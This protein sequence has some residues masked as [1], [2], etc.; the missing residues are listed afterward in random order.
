LT[1]RKGVLAVQPADVGGAAFV[2]IAPGDH[3]SLPE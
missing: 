1:E 3:C 2:G